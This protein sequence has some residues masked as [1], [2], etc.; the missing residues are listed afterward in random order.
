MPCPAFQK[1]NM[2]VERALQ[3]LRAT[4]KKGPVQEETEILSMKFEVWVFAEG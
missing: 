3:A 2:S 4:A 1:T